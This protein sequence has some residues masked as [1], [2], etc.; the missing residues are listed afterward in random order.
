MKGRKE[1]KQ[2]LCASFSAEARLR[3]TLGEVKR[4]TLLFPD[5]MLAAEGLSPKFII[6]GSLL[7][8]R[9]ESITYTYYFENAGSKNKGINL[10]RFLSIL[11]YLRNDYE[12]RI[13][14]F[15]TPILETI[16]DSLL[17]MQ[18]NGESV[19]PVENERMNELGRS[20]EALSRE[21]I[22]L[23][24]KNAELGRREVIFRKF[25]NRIMERL[26]HAGASKATAKEAL[27]KMGID[28]Q[29]SNEL[30]ELLSS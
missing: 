21:T 16:E 12:V 11:A 20:N 17:L 28:E 13:D 7:E 14:S 9:K 8:L 23:L 26:P 6:G 10:A 24:K 29:L 2:R 19:D 3:S 27:I 18:E 22:S 15:Y 4:R 30:L 1:V 5:T 25:S